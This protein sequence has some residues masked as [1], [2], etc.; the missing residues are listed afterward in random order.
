MT[1][2][3]KTMI[4]AT[5]KMDTMFLEGNTY[6]I[7]SNN[8]PQIKTTITTPMAIAISKMDSTVEIRTSTKRAT[9]RATAKVTIRTATIKDKTSRITSRIKEIRINIIE[10]HKGCKINVI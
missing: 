4:K 8:M 3:S 7:T 10:K 2:I 5:I 9:R 6:P 1:T